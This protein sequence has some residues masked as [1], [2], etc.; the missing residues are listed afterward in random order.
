MKYPNSNKVY[1]KP[2]ESTSN[3]GMSLED[4]INMTNRYYL[5]QGIAVV[6]KK[7]TPITI[8]HVDY[9]KRSAAKITEAYFKVASTTD[10][11]G[12]YLGKY[13]DFEAKECESKTSFPFSSIH[14]H[15][16]E[17]LSEVLKH[18]AIAFIILRMVSYNKDFLIK[19]NDFIEFYNSSERKSL[20]YSWIEENGFVIERKYQ[21][22]C[23]YL[24]VAK[25]VFNL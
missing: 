16:I 20:P 12:I 4:D 11:N 23:D 14:S 9:P 5:N 2:K 8:V 19:A 21:K 22:P 7:P 25:E 10:Y 13:I 18:G 6:H 17:H 1:V 24:A 15:Q 3:R